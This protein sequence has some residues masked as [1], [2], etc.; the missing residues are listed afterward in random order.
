MDNEKLFTYGTIFLLVAFAWFISS[1]FKVS[2][3]GYA[4]SNTTQTEA[5]VD[6]NEFI[7]LTLQEG[8]PIDFGSLDPG[9]TNSSASTNPSNV[10]I[11]DETNVDFNITLNATSHFNS[12]ESYIIQ[13]GNMRFQTTNRTTQPTFVLN[14]EDD[15]FVWQD[16][17]CGSQENRS[18]LFFIDIPS[19]QRASST[20][21]ANLTIGASGGT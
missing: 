13:I 11:G 14:T 10:T 20:Y 8:F 4:T 15:A 9:T 1:F 2:I 6:I 5:T 12:S 17:P 3:T 21:S 7:S 19:G 16:C 18:I